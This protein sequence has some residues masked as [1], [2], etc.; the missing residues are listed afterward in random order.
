MYMDWIPCKHHT[1]SWRPSQSTLEAS[2]VC[3]C[4]ALDF[5][6]APTLA[7]LLPHMRALA[8]PAADDPGL[9]SLGPLIA[10]LAPTDIMGPQRVPSDTYPP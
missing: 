5:H 2:L 3:A 7:V 10:A 1:L 8:Y 6:T 9:Q 4:T